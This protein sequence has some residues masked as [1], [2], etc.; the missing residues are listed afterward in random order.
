MKAQMNYRVLIPVLTL[1]FALG[2]LFTTALP[3]VASESPDPA[4]SAGE[5]KIP[6]A[7]FDEDRN[8][9]EPDLNADPDVWEIDSWSRARVERQPDES[10]AVESPFT[11]YFVRIQSLLWNLGAQLTGFLS[12]TGR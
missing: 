2:L 4:G 5:V 1:V 7:E 6:D 11:S 3:A 8:P 10:T 12:G 9:I